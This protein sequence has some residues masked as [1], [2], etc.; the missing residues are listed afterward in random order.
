MLTL[1]ESMAPGVWGCRAA[2][3]V[4]WNP[5][6]TKKDSM[7]GFIESH[8]LASAFR[9]LLCSPSDFVTKH[10]VALV[11]S[12]ENRELVERIGYRV[13]Q[14]QEQV[15][16]LDRASFALQHLPSGGATFLLQG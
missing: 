10:C 11:I 8:G 13:G 15:A 14:N 2:E 3:F 16:L 1:R 6:R 7:N 5:L 12:E 9:M 4:R